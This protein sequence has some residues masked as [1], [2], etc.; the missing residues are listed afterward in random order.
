MYEAVYDPDID[1]L[2]QSGVVLACLD[3][4]DP[5][6]LYE[7]GYAHRYGLPVIVFVSAEREEDLKM[8]IGG[9]GRHQA[10]HRGLS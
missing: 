1:G 10:P 3:G 4:L 8:P 6:T 2:K 9:G 5:G 7:I